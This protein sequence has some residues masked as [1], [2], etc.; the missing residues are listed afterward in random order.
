MEI[1]LNII[2]GAIT[3][4]SFGFALWQHHRIKLTEQVERGKLAVS[5]QRIKQV[6]NTAH[7]IAYAA[8]MIVQRS[9]SKEDVGI[10]ELQNIARAI[11]AQTMVLI[12]ELKSERSRMDDWKY[13]LM[14]DSDDLQEANDKNNE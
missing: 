3:I 7:S 8:D 5:K 10:S 1:L 4:A 2:F 12:T 13:G 9:K 6:Y 11:R 14:I